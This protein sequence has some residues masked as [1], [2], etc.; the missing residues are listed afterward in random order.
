MVQLAH[1]RQWRAPELP[2]TLR[3]MDR[4]TG[5]RCAHPVPCRSDHRVA[6]VLRMSCAGA[7]AGVLDHRVPR[8]RYRRNDRSADHVGY[9]TAPD[10]LLWNER[11]EPGPVADGTG[12]G[13][14]APGNGC[15]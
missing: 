11:T 5:A 1:D 3:V 14:D 10:V 13:A 2:G 6:F 9:R 12:L 15:H 4:P 7:C 8:A